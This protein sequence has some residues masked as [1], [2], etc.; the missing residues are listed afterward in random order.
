MQEN[1]QNLQANNEPYCHYHMDYVDGSFSCFLSQKGEDENGEILYGRCPFQ[2]E[3]VF[4]E[5]GDEGIGIRTNTGRLLPF[6]CTRFF[7]SRRPPYLGK[8]HYHRKQDR[9]GSISE[10]V[11]R[12]V[13]IAVRGL[14]RLLLKRIN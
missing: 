14:M 9:F 13:R 1:Q 2:R 11:V 12:R 5:N 7:S 10:R 8:E 6:Y 3:D 4:R